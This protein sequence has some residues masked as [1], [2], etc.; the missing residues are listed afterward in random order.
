MPMRRT[1]DKRQGIKAVSSQRVIWIDIAK[2]IAM[3][4]VFYGHLPGDGSNPWFPN[5]EQVLGLCTNSICHCFSFL[6]V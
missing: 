2:G 6:V 3:L 5:L 4:L 1:E